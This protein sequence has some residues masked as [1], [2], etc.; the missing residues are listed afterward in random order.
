MVVR[1]RGDFGSFE[2]G[3]ERVGWGSTEGDGSHCQKIS[4][5]DKRNFSGCR[6]L[7]PDARGLDGNSVGRLQLSDLPLPVEPGSRGRDRIFGG[8]AS[9][10]RGKLPVRFGSGSGLNI[11]RAPSSQALFRSLSVHFNLHRHPRLGPADDFRRSCSRLRPRRRCRCGNTDGEGGPAAAP[12]RRR[13]NVLLMR[14]FVAIPVGS[15]RVPLLSKLTP[16]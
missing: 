9:R 14:P 15:H 12:G 10:H 16:S 3:M 2:L 7:Q 5:T 8:R 11:H 1:M 6:G 4:A 13:K